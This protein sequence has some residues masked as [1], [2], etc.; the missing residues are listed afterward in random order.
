MVKR[1][2]DSQNMDEVM[3]ENPAVAHIR[4][5]VS[6]INAR[7]PGPIQKC[8]GAEDLSYYILYMGKPGF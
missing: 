5:M 4:G 2:H 7:G 6:L 8:Y 3:I 1:L